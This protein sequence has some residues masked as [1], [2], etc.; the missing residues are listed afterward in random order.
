MMF[1][2]CITFRWGNVMRITIKK[3][4]NSA[5]IVIPGIVLNELDLKVGQSMEA[6]VKDNKLIL[7]PLTRKR[8]TLEELLAQCDMDAQVVSEEEIWGKD[9]PVGNEAW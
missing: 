7:K 4:G 5:G 9:S 1:I 3:W 2:L 8:Y 6:E